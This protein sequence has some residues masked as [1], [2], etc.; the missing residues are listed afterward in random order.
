MSVRIENLSGRVERVDQKLDFM[1]ERFNDVVAQQ[2]A[3][4]NE[5]KTEF[6]TTLR[7]MVVGIIGAALSTEALRVVAAF[8]L[9]GTP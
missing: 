8:V 7:W 3:A 5:L 1:A 9:K 2:T 4:L 6:R